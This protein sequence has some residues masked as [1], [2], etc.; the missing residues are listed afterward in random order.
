[1][2]FTKT[3]FLWAALIWAVSTGSGWAQ[4]QP[5]RLNADYAC[6]RYDD[7]AVFVEVFYSVKGAPQSGM[8]LTVFRNDSVWTENAWTN[9]GADSAREGDTVLGRVYFVAPEG[10]Y[11]WR[12]SARDGA[13]NLRRDSVLFHQSIQ[14]FSNERLELS[15][16]ELASSIQFASEASAGSPFFKN[17]MIILPNPTLQF[18]SRQ[19]LLYFY[20]EL[21]NVLTGIEGERYVTRVSVLNENRTPVPEIKPIS[22]KKMKT[23]GSIMD[24]GEIGLF[25]LGSGKYILSYA[26]LDS[27]G[28][29]LSEKQKP[30]WMVRPPEAVFAVQPEPQFESSPFSA[31]DEGTM[32]EEYECARYLMDA[33]QRKLFSSIKN[34]DARRR[35]MYDFWR[36]APAI[37]S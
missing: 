30:F 5:L 29:V 32:K 6:F 19:N 18:G 31:M 4:P 35:W 23:H 22:R 2:K 14:P 26:V 17:G 33:Q 11:R 15:D 36:T 21:Y 16:I 10:R 20:V 25:G 9:T 12:L 7:R 37:H 1:M 8:G 27:A 24:F 3:P 34:L 28:R 13:S